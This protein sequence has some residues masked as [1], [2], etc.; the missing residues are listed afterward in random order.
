M[1]TKVKSQKRTEANVRRKV[2][3]DW[4]DNKKPCQ[5]KK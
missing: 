1:A 5:E 3:K 4:A 2:A